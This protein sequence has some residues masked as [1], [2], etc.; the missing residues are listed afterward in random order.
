MQRVLP[1]LQRRDRAVVDLFSLWYVVR[2]RQRLTMAGGDM[3]QRRPT[4]RG[5][6]RSAGEPNRALW[7]SWRRRLLARGF[8]EQQVSGL[9]VLKLVYL[10][11]SLRD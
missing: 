3:D 7:R 5:A 2:T 4:G 11:G 9:I 6:A 10:R 1:G 8:T